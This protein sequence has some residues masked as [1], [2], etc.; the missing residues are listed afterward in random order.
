M[1]SILSIGSSA[2]IAAQVGIEVT[3]HNIANASTQGYN[4]QVIVQGALPGQDKGYGFLGKGTEILS[5]K[6][7]YNDYLT[8]HLRATQSTFSQLDS[9]YTEIQQI[10]SMLADSTVGLSPSL[11]AFFGSLQDVA[12]SP[13]STVTRQTM[14]SS[15]QSLVASFQSLSGQLGEI[16]TGINSQIQASVTDINSYAAQIAS[17]ND[18]IERVMG[19]AVSGV[20]NDLLDQRD[21]LIAEL[22]AQV[23]VSVVKQGNSYDVYIGNGQPLVVGASNHL[24]VA[25]N[26]DTDPNRLEVAYLNQDGST[27][28]MSSS[29]INGGTLAG[30]LEFRSET[31][32]VARNSLGRMA[33]V[34]ASS[35][36]AQHRLGMDLNGNVGS[37]S[38]FLTSASTTINATVGA[39]SVSVDDASLFSS[40]GYTLAYDG[41][42]YT[43]TRVSDSSILSS[44]DFVAAQAAAET[45]GFSLT[46]VTAMA[47]GDS[48]TIDSTTTAVGA[49]S[50]SVINGSAVSTGG[51]RLAYDGTNYTLTRLSD[52]SVLSSTDLAAAQ[53]AAQTEGFSFAETTALNAGNAMTLTPTLGN[54]FFNLPTPLVAASSQNTSSAMV[55][56][57]IADATLLT[58]SDYSLFYD[59]TNYTLKRLSDSR[60]LSATTLE[61][62]Q[63]AAET[64][65]F[66]FDVSGTMDPG[67][68]FSIRPTANGAADIS[69]AITDVAEIA[70]AAPIA[71]S[72]GSANTGSGSISAGSVQ[73]LTQATLGT[74]TITFNADGTYNIAGSGEGLPVNNVTYTAGEEIAYNGWTVAISGTPAA[75]D[76]F[77]IGANTSG[78]GD[79]RNALLLAGLQTTN[80]VNGRTATFQSAY[81][82]LVNQIGNKTSEL[83]TTSDSAK[84]IYTNAYNAIQS[85]SGVNLDEEAANLLRYQQYYQA[86]A[87]VMQVASELF[88]TLLAIK[89]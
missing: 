87:R 57:S 17:L 35:F 37:A 81:S 3:G 28:V 80:L 73:T 50:T 85:E 72:V 26:S 61:A 31:L 12:S 82:Q 11:Q 33:I 47:L 5:V 23:S 51:Y 18:A 21:Q 34:L 44:T 49:I 16:N 30:L 56:A 15:S 53:A 8:T 59:G 27:S 88:D 54:D 29:A 74:V 52:N 2:L 77:S 41:T 38:D 60:V 6:R 48:V 20:P 7:I 62:A 42:N 45:Q 69:V 32:D 79:N 65:G 40:G 78:V 84:T 89:S 68:S 67:D 71:T 83:K 36:N 39:V 43:L 25:Q 76:T 46:E 1:S 14:L 55:S 9:Y 64:Q 66:A 63:A 19:S 86:A 24:L 70:A 58:T 10:D 22:S 75:G 4:R 13:S